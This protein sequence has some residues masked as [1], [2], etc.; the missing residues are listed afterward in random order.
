MNRRFWLKLVLFLL[1]ADALIG[2][3]VTIVGGRSGIIRL[4]PVAARSQATDLFLMQ[5]FEI[6]ALRLGLAC[7]WV[8]TAR[9]PESN[10]AV[11][12]GTSL[13]LVLI[14]VAEIGAPFLLH[15]QQL[16]PWY[17]VAAH[18]GLRIALG[19]ALFALRPNSSS[20]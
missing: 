4:L 9:K 15:T 18:A 11:I 3:L 5:K 14:A 12:L 20:A 13:A 8:L 16:Y 7:M 2:S 1:A 19:V 6:S 17:L 10:S